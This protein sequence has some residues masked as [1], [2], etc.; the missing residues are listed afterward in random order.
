MGKNVT[1]TKKGKRK[2][3]RGWFRGAEGGAVLR[4]G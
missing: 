2:D 4:K 1:R 3:E